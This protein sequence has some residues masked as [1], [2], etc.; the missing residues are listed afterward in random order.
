MDVCVE[1]VFPA[2]AMPFNPFHEGAR[3]ENG[4]PAD[5]SRSGA[6]PNIV[7]VAVDAF[8]A[9]VERALDPKLRGKPVLVGRGVVV[10]A[11]YE[12]TLC[13]VEAGMA[14]D[15]A[16]RICP[17]AMVAPGNYEHYAD[18]AERVRRIL[19]NYATTV[20]AAAL[21]DFYLDFSGMQRR[22]AD[23][24]ATLRCVQADVLE[25]TGLS[26]S[27]G[28]ARTRVVASLASR[29]A[30]P[31]GLRVI[32]AGTEDEF[33]APLPVQELCGIGHPRARAFAERGIA[34]LGQLRLVPRASLEA[35]FGEAIGRK[36][37][38]GARGR[39]GREPT[40]PA[41]SKPVSR[42]A[43]IERGTTEAEFLGGLI[44]YLS[45]RIAATLRERGR[46]AS[47]IGLRIRYADQFTASQTARLTR[48]THDPREL[49]SEASELL[50]ELFARRVPVVSVEVSVTNLEEFP[51]RA[52]LDGCDVAEKVAQHA[53]PLQR[54]A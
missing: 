23:Y 39:D 51:G 9:S 7:H 29:L 16:L 2:V 20:E 47:T 1:N 34:T 19:E 45:E 33:L 8:F 41:T 11:S 10:S 49:R 18:F 15:E 25:R 14:F 17:H 30:G 44:E 37:W 32:A 42:E 6:I 26:V 28:A 43:S 48:P 31:R 3:E 36:V 12:A 53:A 21:D 46:R 35:A 5:A 50:A 22:Y 38:E 54:T 40:Q 4:R 52:A 27:I 13:G 24:E